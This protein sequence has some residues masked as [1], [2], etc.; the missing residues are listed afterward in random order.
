MNPSSDP[1]IIW[2]SGEPG[3]SSIS[4]LLNENGPFYPNPDGST[5]FENLYSWNKVFKFLCSLKK[6][7]IEKKN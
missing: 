3:C 6:M 7:D 1:L 5:L 2:F 4:G